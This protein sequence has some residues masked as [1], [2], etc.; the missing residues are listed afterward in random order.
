LMALQGF[1]PKANASPAPPV[2]PLS[3]P[4]EEFAE[5]NVDRFVTV[6]EI[7][8]NPTYGN[9]PL[10][11]GERL[12]A[13]TVPIETDS[14]STA[15]LAI[16]R[17]IGTIEILE[18]T[19]LQVK[20]LANSTP[21]GMTVFYVSRGQ[22]RLSL[23]SN[24]TPVSAAFST[25]QTAVAEKSLT[26]QN[27]AAPILVAQRRRYPVSV[28]TP[29]GV[30]G[31]QGTSFGVNVAP[32]GKTGVATLD[33]TVAAVGESGQEVLVP[34]GHY[35]VLNPGEPTVIAEETPEKC[36]LKI[37]SLDRLSS[38]RVR[39]VGRAYPLDVVYINGEAIETDEEGRFSA[40]IDAP[41]RMLNFSIRGPAVRRLSYNLPI[42]R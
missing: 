5:N 14:S 7:R 23:R 19:S 2:S 27:S 18:N 34:E 20:T 37:R 11:V 22:V 3:I 12:Q 6:E 4:S 29:G 26:A 30:A 35:A 24:L 8:G 36:V 40:T 42:R 31:V 10:Q 9:R 17:Q 32:D 28:E 16:D 15:M 13:G 41:Q 1:F 25:G 38:R 39:V 33:G 21:D